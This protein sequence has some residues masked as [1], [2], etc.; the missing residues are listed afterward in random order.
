MQRRVT[1][2]SS[3]VPSDFDERF[4]VAMCRDGHVIGYAGSVLFSVTVT[5]PKL[6]SYDVADRLTEQLIRQY[7]NGI[8]QLIVA[9]AGLPMPPPENRKRIADSMSRYD[10]NINAIAMVFQ[11][12]GLWASSMRVVANTMMMVIPS[13][14]PRRMFGDFG[15]GA[16]WLIETGL[17]D[18][19]AFAASLQD[20]TRA[21]GQHLAEAQ[22]EARAG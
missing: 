6:A 17:D 12:G 3:H 10:G 21:A 16:N 11:G 8:C 20:I 7:P 2:G 14:C 4:G 19:G 15:S 1:K 22:L 18:G 5:T 13:R 9:S